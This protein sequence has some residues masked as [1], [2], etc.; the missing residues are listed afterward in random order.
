V[1]GPRPVESPIDLAKRLNTLN[2]RDRSEQYQD[3]SGAALLKSNNH[4]WVQVRTLR[5]ML[6]VGGIALAA[7]WGV[8]L[9]FLADFLMRQK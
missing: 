4:L 1:T 8:N 5:L 9:V 3:T 6:W 7:S 2:K